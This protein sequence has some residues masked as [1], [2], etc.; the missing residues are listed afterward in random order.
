MLLV[1]H[2]SVLR[3]CQYDSQQ[4]KDITKVSARQHYLVFT[5]INSQSLGREPIVTLNVGTPPTPFHIHRSLLCNASPVF[6]AAFHGK[7]NFQETETQ[8]MDLIDDD[9]AA[10]DVISRWL[11][12]NTCEFAEEFPKDM[13]FLARLATFKK[14]PHVI[15]TPESIADAGF[16]SDADA[17]PGAALDRVK[18]N[19][20]SQCLNDWN[21]AHNALT[22]HHI[23]S[24]KC[25]YVHEALEA[26]NP[27][28]LSLKDD[29]FSGTYF[30]RLTSIYVTAEKYCMIALKNEIIDLFFRFRR[31]SPRP[32][33]PSSDIISYIY[34]NTPSN[35]PLRQLVV[36]WYTWHV[37]KEWYQQDTTRV[38]LRECP[39]FAVD[40]A[41]S[42]SLKANGVT[43]SSPLDGRSDIYHEE[44]TK[45][46]A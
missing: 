38:T 30:T 33:P 17:E 24:S 22:Q 28:R 21:S 2:G 43:K 3:R 6:N 13:G 46:Q 14:W 36:D 25:S 37:N 40:L 27:T 15:P 19:R 1:Y 39:D 45:P 34:G 7:G 8:T 4:T 32:K 16:V 18:C 26:L 41:C 44:S 42:M 31:A 29:E 5:S 20:C 10:F 11:Y 12:T 9:A 35:S 23:W